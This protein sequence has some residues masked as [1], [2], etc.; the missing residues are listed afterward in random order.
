MFLIRKFLSGAQKSPD[1]AQ[2]PDISVFPAQ[3]FRFF[4]SM[5]CRRGPVDAA[6]YFIFVVLFDAQVSFGDGE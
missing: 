6:V 2:S 4:N 5:L 3:N 1:C